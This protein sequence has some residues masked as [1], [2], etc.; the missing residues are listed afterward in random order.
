MVAKEIVRES[1]GEDGVA[2]M[3]G[4]DVGGSVLYRHLE[5]VMV[6]NKG[7]GSHL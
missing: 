5:F 3:H 1:G 7:L 4:D 6:R 2:N